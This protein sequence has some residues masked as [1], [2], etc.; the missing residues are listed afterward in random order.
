MAQSNSSSSMASAPSKYPYPYN[1]N[2]ANFVS[3]KLN[4][5]NFLLWQTQMTGLIESQDMTSFQD[6][7]YQPPAQFLTAS[8][9]STVTGLNPD[10]LA[11]R[12]SDRLFN[13]WIT[14]TLAEEILGII[15][16]QQTAMKVW[17][18]L[19]QHFANKSQ[20]REMFLMQKLQMHNKGKS[21][22]DEYIRSFKKISD[23]LAAIGKPITDETKVFWL[24]TGLTKDYESFR[25][26]LST[27]M[28]KPPAPSYL[29]V[30]A[31]LQNHET[32]RTLEEDSPS[33]HVAFFSYRQPNQRPLGNNSKQQPTSGFFVVH[34][35]VHNLFKQPFKQPD[36]IKRLN[37]PAEQNAD[38]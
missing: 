7:E 2:V 18:T 35:H 33:T 23:E 15:I 17:T 12:K 36:G 28:L 32:M 11:W 30:V 3:I 26:T 14:G 22:V 1:L 16:G 6:G 8:A 29:E 10:Y 20:E 31:L 21:S 37:P 34:F 9:E 13:G 38:Q 5:G 27:T 19:T 24:L 25:T 4:Q